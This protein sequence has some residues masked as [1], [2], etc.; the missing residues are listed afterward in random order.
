MRDS[1]K[2]YILTPAEKMER[3]IKRIEYERDTQIAKVKHLE[4]QFQRAQA[5]RQKAVDHAYNEGWNAGYKLAKG[6]K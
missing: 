4:I 5:E 2:P 6:G 1:E 3:A